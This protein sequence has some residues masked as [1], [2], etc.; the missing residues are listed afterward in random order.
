MPEGTVVKKGDFLVELDSSALD[1]Q[2]TTQKIAVNA[3][4]AAEVEAH[5]TYETAIIAKREYLE[6]TYLQDR[7]TIESEVFVAEENLNRAKEY[8]SL[9]S[10]AGLEG[11]RQRVAIGSRP[12]RRRESARRISTRP[13]RSSRARRV[14]QTEDGLDARERYLDRQGEMGRRP[15]AATSSNW[16]SCR[17]SMT[18]SPSARSLR[19]RTAW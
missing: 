4:K 13:R 2:R 17:N 7:Q 19:R 11:L 3:A 14:H 12:L 15:R 9:Q 10:E 6:G 16:K 18:R 1:A 8:Y 5:N